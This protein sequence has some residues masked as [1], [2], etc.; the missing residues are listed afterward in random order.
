MVFHL[1]AP[2]LFS[3]ES[4][5]QASSGSFKR[6]RSYNQTIL[7]VCWI[8]AFLV[9]RGALLRMAFGQ[10]RKCIWR[11]E[12]HKTKRCI[13]GTHKM[14]SQKESFPFWILISSCDFQAIAC[15]FGRDWVHFPEAGDL[16]V[17]RF[18]AF[19]IYSTFLN[20]HAMKPVRA[21]VLQAYSF[22]L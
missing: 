4:I 1:V 6:H 11:A 9:S 22:W 2:Q 16:V 14:L 5:K 3:I 19:G 10:N 8:C 15:I 7:Y 12:L 17:S 21:S 20:L 18:D 13:K